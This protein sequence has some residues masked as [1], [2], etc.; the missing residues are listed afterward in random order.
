M[1]MERN[2][3]TIRITMHDVPE[4]VPC[5]SSKGWLKGNG[6]IIDTQ[7]GLLK[8]TRSNVTTS[9]GKRRWISGA[10]E[11]ILASYP[12]VHCTTFESV[13]DFLGSEGPKIRGLPPEIADD[14]AAVM[15]ALHRGVAKRFLSN[16][17]DIRRSPVLVCLE[18]MG[19]T[20]CCRSK[21]VL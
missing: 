11:R 12:E 20:E 2:W 17:L 10:K 5:L 15:V 8:L 21:G 19:S 1:G 9:M 4:E 13:G 7:A 6:A 14:G 16:T 18:N 3:K